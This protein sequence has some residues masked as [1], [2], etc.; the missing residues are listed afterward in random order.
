MFWSLNSSIVL[1]IAELVEGE[2]NF[3]LAN[4]K[5]SFS[6]YKIQGKINKIIP[7]AVQSKHVRQDDFNNNFRLKVKNI[8]LAF[9]Y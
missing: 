1:Q 5:F 6:E 8:S 3:P 4:N 9:F 7:S 2:F